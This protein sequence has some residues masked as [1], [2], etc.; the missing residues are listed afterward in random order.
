MTSINTGFKPHWIKGHNDVDQQVAGIINLS[1]LFKWFFFFGFIK[2]NE[3]NRLAEEP[4][5]TINAYF[6]PINFVNAIAEILHKNGIWHF[7]QSYMP[8]MLKK[9]SYDTICHEHLEYYSVK[10]L[11]VLLEKSSGSVAGS[12][13]IS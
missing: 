6:D 1:P 5:F 13:S 12:R 11:N 9:N 2:A 4:E 7:E 10:A 3:D 8:I